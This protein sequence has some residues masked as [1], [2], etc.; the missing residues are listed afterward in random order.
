MCTENR[1]SLDPLPSKSLYKN[2]LILFLALK[3][4]HRKPDYHSATGLNKQRAPTGIGPLLFSPS[5][6][7]RAK[8]KRFLS[9]KVFVAATENNKG[10]KEMIN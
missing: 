8:L 7:L 4:K 3:T 6:P 10:P 2:N 9:G 5:L 1:N